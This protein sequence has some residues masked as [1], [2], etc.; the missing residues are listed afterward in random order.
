MSHYNKH[1]SGVE[2]ID[3]IKHENFN[4]GNAIKYIWRRNHKGDP[5]GDLL[6]AIYYLE[7]EIAIYNILGVG[8]IDIHSQIS[9]HL[10]GIMGNVERVCTSSDD[11]YIADSEHPL[12]HFINFDP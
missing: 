11:G 2:C 12:S 8:N 5:V 3:I 6:K 9:G 4:I 10:K 1:P 7:Q